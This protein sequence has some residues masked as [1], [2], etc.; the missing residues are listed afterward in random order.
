MDTYLAHLN[1]SPKRYDAQSIAQS[2][3]QSMKSVKSKAYGMES[4][5]WIGMDASI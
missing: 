1:N 5:N 4:G 3:L 2:N